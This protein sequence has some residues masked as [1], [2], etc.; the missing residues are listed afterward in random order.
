[1][2]WFPCPMEHLG[3]QS[4]VSPGGDHHSPLLGEYGMGLACWG[5]LKAPVL[6]LAQERGWLPSWCPQVMLLCFILLMAPGFKSKGS[7][8]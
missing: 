6:E 4:A 7:G 2:R 5:S 3:R 1:M 8:M